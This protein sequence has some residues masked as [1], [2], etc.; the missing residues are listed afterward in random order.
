MTRCLQL[1]SALLLLQHGPLCGAFITPTVSPRATVA[2]RMNAFPDFPSVLSSAGEDIAAV[3]DRADIPV[4]EA[5]QDTISFTDGPVGV[6]V[7]AFAVFVVLAVGF[8]A[9]M[10]QMDSAIEQ[11]IADFESTMKQFYPERWEEIEQSSLEGLEGDA[12]DIELLRVMEEL[13]QK[14]PAFMS[15][16]ADRSTGS[17]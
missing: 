4:E 1:L 3:V 10:G 17:R 8:K 11:V 15:Q 9:V 16:V 5:F 14:D 2:S 12:R 13:Q 6:L 7:A